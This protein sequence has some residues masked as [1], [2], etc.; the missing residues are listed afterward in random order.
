MPTMAFA[1]ETRPGRWELRESVKTPAG[2]RARTLASFAEL[3]AEHIHLI[4]ERSKTGV[5]AGDAVQA[6]RR[7]GA[8][9]ALAPADA[10]A[11]ALL[12]TIGDGRQISPGL[13]RLLVDAL[14]DGPM[15]PA[16]QEALEYIGLSAKQRGAQLVDLLLLTNAIAPSG[17]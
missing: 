7:A 2:P 1:T 17:R 8:P 4:V 9:V 10:A 5:S 12:R 16:T 13:K 6:A 14:G 15:R 11:I 3:D